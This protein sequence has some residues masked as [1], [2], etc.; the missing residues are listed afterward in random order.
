MSAQI[1]IPE[2]D[3]MTK[4]PAYRARVYRRSSSMNDLC[5]LSDK[6]TWR[7]RRWL[8]KKNPRMVVPA[9][10]E[11]ALKNDARARART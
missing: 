10:P 4:T 6:R 11:I 7:E 1:S 3:V 5:R 9:T 8:S 2:N